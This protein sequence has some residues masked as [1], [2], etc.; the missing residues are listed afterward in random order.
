VKKLF[1]IWVF[2]LLGQIVYAQS[3]VATR[4]DSVKQAA[5]LRMQVIKAQ[6]AARK[7]SLAQA[8]KERELRKK[9]AEK[10]KKKAKKRDLETFAQDDFTRADT[11]R[12]LARARRDSIKTVRQA[13]AELRKARE[14]E[15][16]GQEAVLLA[17]KK[18]ALPLTQEMGFG[19]RLNSDG[20]TCFT[21]RGFIDPEK[22]VTTFFTVDISEKKHPKETRSMNENFSVVY[23]NEVKP[24]PYKYGKINNFYQIK[25]G[26]GAM[27]E[28]SGRLDK[29]S[30]TISW[31]YAG[32]LSIGLLKPYYLDLLVPEGAGYVRKFEKYTDQTKEYFLDLNNSGTILGGSYFTK[33]IG[34]L[35][36]EPGLHARS[37]FYFD[38][39]TTRKSFVGVEVGASIEAYM[40]TI[41]IMAN[42]HNKPVFLNFYADFRLGKRWE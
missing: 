19:F 37:G 27:R 35:N 21:S 33:G 30:V 39:S 22:K 26:Y 34:E 14:A 12:M 42:A 28:L 23:P 11:L 10:K 5:L 17:K 18:K 38:Y 2:C 8:K 16:K 6:Q 9:E 4:S 15:R 24:L 29:K 1:A 3:A 36:I 20:W 7:D 25:L 13:E 41:D 40:H 32:G 31:V